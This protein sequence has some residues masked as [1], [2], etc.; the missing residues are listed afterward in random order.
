MA[1]FIGREAIWF[2]ADEILGRAEPA[3]GAGSDAAAIASQ[4][5]SGNSRA[6]RAVE[7]VEGFESRQA[8]ANSSTPAAEVGA[9]AFNIHEPDQ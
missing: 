6:N 8:S 9:L 7:R 5:S 3:L 4:L 2:P 1:L